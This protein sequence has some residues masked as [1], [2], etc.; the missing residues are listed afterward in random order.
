[1]NITY[2]CSDRLEDQ[3]RV[4]IRIRNLMDAINRTGV[5]HAQMIN[6]ESF[7]QNTPE[8]QSIC[9]GSE[10][11]VI[12]RYLYGQILTAIQY[13]KAREKKVVVDFDLA[14]NILS[15]DHPDYPLWMQG[16][17]LVTND[18][19]ISPDSWIDPVPLE[20]FKWGLGSVDAATV[21]SDWLVNDW[22]QFTRMYEISDYIN[23]Y[24][25]PISDQNHSGE[26]W[27]GMGYGAYHDSFMKSGLAIA[28]ERICREYPNVKLLYCMQGNDPY[29][30]LMINPT[31]I[32]ICAPCEFDTWVSSFLLQLDIGLVPV[33]S[34]FDL[35]LSPVNMLE[36]MIA[37]IPWISSKQ[38]NFPK[39]SRYGHWVKN[40]PDAW[41]SAV[42][43]VVE[44][45][46]HYKQMAGGEPFLYAL[47]QDIGV[48]LDHVLRIYS[49]IINQ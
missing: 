36:F 3:I 26:I 42:L 48:N 37:K 13:W 1:V 31:Q 16:S 20:Q 43:K 24:Q 28:M 19:V 39:L 14:I 8:A 38:F 2:I 33:Y 44:H 23:T 21:S 4:Q 41:E 27:V 10:I 47:E 45:L 7:A 29:A 40:T 11:L 30:G 9:S 46:E 34:D 17:P 12:Y 6:L 15:P 5:H 22:S 18:A 49:A 35:H 32:Q 25:Y